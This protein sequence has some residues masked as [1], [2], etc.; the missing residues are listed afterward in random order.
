MP[1]AP[2]QHSLPPVVFDAGS[3]GNFTATLTS[4]FG[5]A[6]GDDYRVTISGSGTTHGSLAWYWDRRFGS[7]FTIFS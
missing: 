6:K 3:A 5:W 1:S 7:L 2:F 4:A